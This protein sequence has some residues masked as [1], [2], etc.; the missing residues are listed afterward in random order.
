MEDK[1]YG[2]LIIALGF[3]IAY[4]K[5]NKKWIYKKNEHQ[6]DTVLSIYGWGV[7][8]IMIIAGL[9]LLFS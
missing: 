2:I 6:M 9:F 3:I 8:M 7:V 4:L 5:I 1:T